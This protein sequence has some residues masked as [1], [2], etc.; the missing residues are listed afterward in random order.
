MDDIDHLAFRRL[1]LN[2]LVAF[3]ALLQE[4]NVSRAAA[5]LCIGQPAMSHA[6]AR[7]RELFGDELLYRHGSR[8]EPTPR[9]LALGAQIRPLL[10]QAAALAEPPGPFDP[11][12]AHQHVRIS[13]SDPLEAILLP[14]LISRLRQSSPGIT[15]SVQAMLAPAQLEQLDAGKIS[16]AI[17]YFPQLRDAHLA[18]PLFDT[19]YYCV[20]NPALVPMGPWPTL[21]DILGHPHIHT[22][23]SGDALGLFDLALKQAGLARRVVARSAS[24]LAIPFVVAQSALVAVLPGIVTRLFQRYEELCIAPVTLTGPM[25]I[26][27]VRHRREQANP[28]L[29]YLSGQIRAAVG[30]LTHGEVG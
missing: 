11:A 25:N 3:D 6:L 21:D 24:P 15:L 29:D 23:Y 26:R 10:A 19:P 28:L 12:R 18:E 16:L 17:G 27:L 14:G 7:L 5:R 2:L 13:M 8:M 1:D 9:A 20:F 4:R 22:T 30:E